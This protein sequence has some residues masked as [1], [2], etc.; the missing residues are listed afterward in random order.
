[1]NKSIVGVSD[2]LPGYRALKAAMRLKRTQCEI[3]KANRVIECLLCV[4]LSHRLFVR[5]R[6]DGATNWD[7]EILVCRLNDVVNA[8][9]P[10]RR[11]NDMNTLGALQSVSVVH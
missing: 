4:C 9:L 2:A 10:R 11:L 1:M 7:H 3:Q 5:T 8:P 6:Y